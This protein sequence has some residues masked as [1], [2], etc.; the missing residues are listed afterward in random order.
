MSMTT[1]AE[2][3]WTPRT[4]KCMHT[5]NTR[6]PAPG[7]IQ[8]CKHWILCIFM[9]LDTAEMKALSSQRREARLHRQIATALE[10][11]AVEH[12]VHSAA[13]RCVQARQV[14]QRCLPT[15]GR[16]HNAVQAGHACKS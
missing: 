9:P 16:G 6:G 1:R 11:D 14:Q 15:A 4:G 10:A 8:D 2:S 7:Y 3:D 13:G 12:S 5:M